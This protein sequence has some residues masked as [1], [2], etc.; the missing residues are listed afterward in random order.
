M[1][2]QYGDD[3]ENKS[4][5]LEVEWHNN[6]PTEAPKINLDIFYNKHMFVYIYL[7]CI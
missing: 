7:Y 2:L 4:F 6:Y 1:F 3:G 5:L